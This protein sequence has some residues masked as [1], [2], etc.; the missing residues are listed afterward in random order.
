MRVR[1]LSLVMY[2]NGF[3][4]EFDTLKAKDRKIRLLKHFDPTFSTAFTHML[5]VN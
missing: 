3:W 2:L 5:L 4:I 1:R